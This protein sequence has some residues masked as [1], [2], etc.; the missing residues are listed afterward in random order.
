MAI[1]VLIVE[2][3]PLMQRLLST[4]IGAQDDLKVVGTAGDPIEA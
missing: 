4:I 2:D 1:R 3:S